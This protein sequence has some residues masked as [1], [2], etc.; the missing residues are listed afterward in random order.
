MNYQL[1]LSR[2]RLW[3]FRCQIKKMPLAKSTGGALCRYLKNP[4]N[5]PKINLVVSIG[6]NPNFF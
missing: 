3:F 6:R 5:F 1:R 4:V 2:W